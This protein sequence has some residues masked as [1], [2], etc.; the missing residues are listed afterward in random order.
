MIKNYHFGTSIFRL[1]EFLK[2]EL[3][4]LVVYCSFLRICFVDSDIYSILR[5][6]PSAFFVCFFYSVS[7]LAVAGKIDFGKS[8]KIVE[9]FGSFFSM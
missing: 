7:D 9:K 3:R 5:G 2:F 1:F 4:L 8:L 6:N